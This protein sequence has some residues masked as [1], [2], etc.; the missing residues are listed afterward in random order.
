MVSGANAR[1]VA[2][3]ALSV[4][5]RL[6]ARL[7]RRR[8][9]HASGVVVART[10]RRHGTKAHV[11]PAQATQWTELSLPIT[12]LFDEVREEKSAKERNHHDHSEYDRTPFE[13]E[14]GFAHEMDGSNRH[15]SRG[16]SPRDPSTTVADW[17]SS[18]SCT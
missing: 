7:A 12:N 4:R 2:L 5:I 16:S 6:A 13:T 9:T 18:C 3:R 17:S 15:A 1:R 11:A 10:A 14:Y 8:V